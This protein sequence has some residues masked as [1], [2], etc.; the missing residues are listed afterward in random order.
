MKILTIICEFNPLHNG[1][2]YLLGEAAKKSACDAT[3]CIMSGCFTQRGDICRNDKYT[4]AKHAVLCGADAVI[5]L[6]APFAVA[7]AEIFAAGAVKTA[8]KIPCATHLAFGC[9]LGTESDF[10]CAAE[11]LNGESETFKSALSEMLSSGESYIKSYASAYARCGGDAKFISSPNNILGVEYCKALKK[12]GNDLKILPIGRIGAGYSDV[13][14]GDTICSAAAIR[15]NADSPLIKDKMP[16][17]SYE[18]FTRAKP[19]AERFSRLAADWL[20]LCDKENL[21]RVYGCTE[22][23]ENKLKSAAECS[24]Y[25]DII[26]KCAGKR[27]SKS[28]IKRIIAANL[29]GLYADDTQKFL[30]ADLPLRVLAVKKER[31]DELLPLFKNVNVENAPP[32]GDAEKCFSSTS[33]AF[34]LWR[35]LSAPLICDNPN[36]KM[37]LI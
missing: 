19:N 6:P 5:E 9:E 31:A 20:Y 33:R 16:S 10:S 1:H 18:D 35:H 12:C 23:L 30:N 36:E 29:L 3:V 17:F 26:E 22:G 21:K 24:A 27:Y 11:I 32:E 28:R 37:I 7:P 14:L 4:R 8:C 2:A 25:D 13:G 34:A 15:E